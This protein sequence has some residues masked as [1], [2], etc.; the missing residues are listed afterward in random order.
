[1]KLQKETNH[2]VA[3]DFWTPKTD[4]T[5]LKH[6]KYIFLKFLHV[7]PKRDPHGYMWATFDGIV[8]G[9]P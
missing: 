8:P 9:K 5:Y 6:I 1:M 4:L 2:G 3:Q 7:N